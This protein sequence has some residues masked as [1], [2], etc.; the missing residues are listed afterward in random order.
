MDAAPAGGILTHPVY[1]AE[2]ALVLHSGHR[3][4]RFEVAGILGEGGMCTVYRAR[5]LGGG[6]DRALKLLFVQ[7]EHLAERLLLEGRLQGALRHPNVVS[8]TDVVRVGPNPGLVLEYVHGPRLDHWL[9]RYRPS[10]DE[11][12]G[13]FRGIVQGVR[14]AHHAGLVHRDLTPANIL[15]ALE[16]RSATPKVSDF[17]IAKALQRSG[18]TRPGSTLGTPEF[19]APEQ[20]RDASAVDARADLWSLGCLLYLLVTGHRPFWG[21]SRLDVWNLVQAGTYAPVRTV[22]PDLPRDVEEAIERCLTVDPSERMESCDALLDLLYGPGVPEVPAVKLS[23]AGASSARDAL[24]LHALEPSLDITDRRGSTPMRPPPR[25]AR[26]LSGLAAAA[27]IAL[28]L[29][30]VLAVVVSRPEPGPTAPSL[31]SVLPDGTPP[32]QP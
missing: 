28:A 29:F 4:D 30:A 2:G 7:D 27:A 15:L 22:V 16:E 25:V 14:A 19:M 12:L 8:V 26:P 5:D 18:G 31:R 10:L 9:K 23:V 32:G 24:P 17:G 21:A 1:T 6:A 11:S 3:V 20:I 13:V